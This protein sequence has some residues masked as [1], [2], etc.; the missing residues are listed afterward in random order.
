M[1]TRR[2]PVVDSG[3]RGSRGR[4]SGF[5]VTAGI[6]ASWVFGDRPPIGPVAPHNVLESSTIPGDGSP[7]RDRHDRL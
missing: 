2:Q 6:G 1:A 5:A 4:V 7:V 3:S